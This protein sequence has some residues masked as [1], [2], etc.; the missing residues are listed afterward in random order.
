MRVFSQSQIKRFSNILDNA[1][2]VIFASVVIQ[3]IVS[4]AGF[5]TLT[6]FNG[7]VTI[8]VIWGASLFFEGGAGSG[9]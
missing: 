7:I 4:G 9:K 3:P 1:G 2:Q 5:A 6:V 8:A